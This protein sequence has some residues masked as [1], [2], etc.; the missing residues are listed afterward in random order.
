[1]TDA[2]NYLDF[3]E[4]LFDKTFDEV[5]EECS[6]ITMLTIG[7]WIIAK[8]T[9]LHPNEDIETIREDIVNQI[10]QELSAELALSVKQKF[11]DQFVPLELL[12]D[13]IENWT[14]EFVTTPLTEPTLH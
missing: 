5:S 2:D 7:R 13:H 14:P 12:M 9:L 1:M 4:Q 10:A 6:V 3:V 8:L 11:D